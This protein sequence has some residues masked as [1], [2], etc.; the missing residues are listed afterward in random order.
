[1]Y[2]FIMDKWT[3]LAPM[4]ENRTSH[5]CG[6]VT[7]SDDT[8]EL[9]VAGGYHRTSVE[10]YNFETQTWRYYSLLK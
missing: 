8:K 6:L 2:D 4:Q 1:M 5:A 10:I 7:L 9:V 3:E